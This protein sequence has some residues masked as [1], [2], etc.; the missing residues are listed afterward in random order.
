MSQ[1]SCAKPQSK[2]FTLIEIMI[3]ML[4]GVLLIA[5]VL[6]VFITSKQSYRMQEE[7]SRLQEGGRFALDFLDRDIRM[8]GFGDVP[9]NHPHP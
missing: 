1:K 4:I 8:T 5:G 7:L 2:G 3:A 9:V 6:Q